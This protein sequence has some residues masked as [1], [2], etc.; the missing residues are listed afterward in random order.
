MRYKVPV[1]CLLAIVIATYSVPELVE[2]QEGIRESCNEEI[3]DVK[4]TGD[5]FVPKTLIVKIGTTVVWTNT[6][7]GRHT[8]TSGSP[9][10]VT[11]P[12]KSL[13]VEK[14]GTYEFTFDVSGLFSGSYR[15][16][17]QVTKTMRGEIIVMEAEPTIPVEETTE[18]QTL[19]ID[20]EDP[21]SGVK[22]V[23]L[24]NGSIKSMEINLDA[25]I[26]MISVEIDKING[27][28][29]ITLERNLI[30]SKVNG[31]DESFQILIN[32]EEG[33]HEET[34]STPEKRTLQIVVPGRATMVEIVGTQVVP[35]I[36]RA[37]AA[38]SEAETI[39]TDYKNDGILVSSAENKLAMARDAFDDGNYATA[40]VLANDA[41]SM[42]N[43]ASQDASLASTAIS[44]AETVIMQSSDRG[45]DVTNAQ[46]LYGLA[47][48]EY[49]NGN[50]A[51]ASDLAEQA[52]ASAM[53]AMK[54]PVNVNPVNADPINASSDTSVQTYTIVGLI[55]AS[56]AG[57]V[58]A[59]AYARSRKRTVEEDT[60]NAV[61]AGELFL[62]EK[63]VI[64]LNKIS[65]LKTHLRDYDK[66]VVIYIA[67]SGGEVFES[68][69]REKFGLPR[70]TVWRLVK[71]LEREEIVEI[72]K[73]GGQNLIRI[74]QEFTKTDQNA[75]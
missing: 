1:A 73:A 38:I 65:R 52:K 75:V 27:R 74:R 39:I 19:K 67:E 24:S 48:Q 12:L 40:E 21:V 43:N 66:D 37:N 59:F 16:F 13:L 42:A 3:C 50:Y 58:G 20:Y 8:V 41:R 35:H 54:A 28:M 31:K 51:E 69:I 46:Q 2:A 15:Y 72:R 49:A 71:R 70:T 5:G 55:A 18:V 29:D 26:L 32:G 23:S 61:P 68:E 14:G 25:P 36:M 9:G 64:D 4:I 6:D 30:D 47:G 34:L 60:A 57:G 63:R 17:D 10:E 11:T 56:A 45:F 22:S 33:F 53:N 62:K 7:D 44:E